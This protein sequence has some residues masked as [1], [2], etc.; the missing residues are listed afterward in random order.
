HPA[1]ALYGP[2]G[3]H[4]SPIGTYLAAATIAR[5]VLG[6]T[7]SLESVHGV[8]AYNGMAQPTED[9]FEVRVTQASADRMCDAIEAANRA[10]EASP[11]IEID[12]P[13]ITFPE[14]PQQGDDLTHAA[15]AGTWAGSMFA[16]GEHQRTAV[17]VAFRSNDLERGATITLRT[18]PMHGFFDDVDIPLE[19]TI[20]ENGVL[21]L[22]CDPDGFGMPF[23]AWLAMQDG[24]L[25]G[26]V[27]IGEEP[28]E[29]WITSTIALE[30]GGND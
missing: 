9:R 27:R 17:T 6:H 4:P 30:R 26:V 8:V 11:L 28:F 7:P 10:V 18:R 24:R 13:P 16:C 22:A 15:L 20:E 14:A 29:R 19:V 25:E 2:D 1:P 21:S 3:A 12:T 5:T 23:R